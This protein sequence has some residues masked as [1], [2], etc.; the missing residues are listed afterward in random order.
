VGTAAVRSQFVVVVVNPRCPPRSSSSLFLIAS[1]RFYEVVVVHRPATTR[2]TSTEILLVSFRLGYRPLLVTA[3]YTVGLQKHSVCV[4]ASCFSSENDNW[5]ASVNWW[6]KIMGWQRRLHFVS[7]SWWLW[8]RF[9]LPRSPVSTQ[10]WKTQR[11]PLIP[12][13]G[14]KVTKRI[15]MLTVSSRLL[16][17]HRVCQVWFAISGSG[18]IVWK[19]CKESLWRKFRKE[20]PRYVWSLN[21][22]T[23]A[24]WTPVVAKFWPT[25]THCFPACVKTSNP[26]KTNPNHSRRE[27][28]QTSGLAGSKKNIQK[29]SGWSKLVQSRLK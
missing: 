26:R 7:S 2:G 8:A 29:K 28:A 9:S 14:A 10:S 20:T 16:G 3:R 25:E 18:I 17:W 21:S 4:V 24:V 5:N 11:Q 27:H 13:T 23:P 19:L 6:S 1:S 15:H 12:S 22:V